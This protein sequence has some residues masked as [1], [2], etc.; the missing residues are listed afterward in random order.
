MFGRP[1]KLTEAKI[2]NV[3]ELI[4]H[5]NVTKEALIKEFNISGVPA[6]GIG[7]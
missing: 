1:P 5:I 3:R 6:Q 4:S 7:N 2:I